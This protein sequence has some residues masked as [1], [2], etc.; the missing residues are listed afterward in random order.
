MLPSIGTTWL[1][2]APGD[3]GHWFLAALDIDFAHKLKLKAY[4][5]GLSSADAG[6]SDE[7]APRVADGGGSG[8]CT[9]WW[10]G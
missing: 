4:H 9:G 5:F 6:M 8:G 10:K 2:G 7:G 3:D 1:A